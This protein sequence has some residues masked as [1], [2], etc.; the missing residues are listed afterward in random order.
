MSALAAPEK[1]EISTEFESRKP[2][3]YDLL[4]SSTRAES[5]PGLPLNEEEA[6]KRSSLV[7]ERIKGVSSLRVG[8]FV[9]DPPLERYCH[10]PFSGSVEA[11]LATM[12]TPLNLL[13]D[14]VSVVSLNIP[15]KRLSIFL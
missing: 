10:L 8:R 15:L 3:G 1:P 13:E 11:A 9:Q 12:A 6:L 14:P 7:G 4:L 2:S 5:A